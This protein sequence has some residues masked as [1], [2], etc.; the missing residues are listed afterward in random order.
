M[1]LFAGG[2]ARGSLGLRDW[3]V[4]G[5][6]SGRRWAAAVCLGTGAAAAPE[7]APRWCWRSQFCV[8]EGCLPVPSH[9][10]FPFQAFAIFCSPAQ[11]SFSVVSTNLP[12]APFPLLKTRRSFVPSVVCCFQRIPPFFV[13]WTL[14]FLSW[15]KEILVFA[16]LSFPGVS[17]VLPIVSC[18]VSRYKGGRVCSATLLPVKRCLLGNVF[19]CFHLR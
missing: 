2:A 15:L 7:P 11:S 8:P 9:T 3:P 13:C 18:A 4:R 1:A 17:P 12:Q 5:D 16:A 14:R 19:S 10:T 6:R